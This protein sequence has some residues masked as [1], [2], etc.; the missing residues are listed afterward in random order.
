[1]KKLT[2][3]LLAAMML[4]SACGTQIPSAGSEIIDIGETVVSERTFSSAPAVPLAITG[5]HTPVSLDI[6]NNFDPREGFTIAPIMFTDTGIDVL[7]SFLVRTPTDTPPALS[8]DGQPTPTLAR[9]EANV[10]IVIPAVPLTY[11][12]VYTLRIARDGQPSITW[13]FQTT[14]RFE[15]ISTL[16]RHQAFNVPLETGIEFNFS[17]DGNTNIEEHFSIYPSVEGR[18]TR[19]G[20][21]TVFM[22]IDPL[23]EGQIYTVT[24]SPGVTLYGT[25]NTISSELV[26]S[27]E[28]TAPSTHQ[29]DNNNASVHFFTSYVEFPSFEAPS[30]DF[31]FN[32][33]RA[34]RTRPPIE[35]NLYEI[36][37]TAQ[38]VA[39]VNRLTNSQNWARWSAEQNFIDTQGLN[40]MLSFEVT[41]R[42]ESPRSSWDE[43][44][45][46]PTNL[47]PGFYLLDVLVDGNRSQMVIQIT[48]LAVQVLSDN[49]RTILWINDMTTGLPAAGA[50]AKTCHNKLP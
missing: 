35:V 36:E 7:T 29:N 11:N 30:V 21:T 12:S 31:W 46:L 33:P 9:Q 50:T 39:A 32:Q 1:M 48:D 44:I 27:F 45:Q 19:H 41:E 34:G 5:E 3:L 25:N 2:A 18:F 23:E 15:I 49:D 26:F 16:P 8:I 24:I 28:T 42:Q 22:P 47:P 13:A 17:I 4:I 40:R 37:T 10:F 38:G 43:A 6:L 14:S 20:S